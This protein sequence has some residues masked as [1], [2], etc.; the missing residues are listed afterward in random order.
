MPARDIEELFKDNIAKGYSSRKPYLR[1]YTVPSPYYHP[2]QSPTGF[3]SYLSTGLPSPTGVLPQTLESSASIKTEDTKT[4]ENQEN[5]LN[6]HKNAT[7]S[8]V[9]PK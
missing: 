9:I 6:D 8:K 7:I 3:H 1:L 2:S 4:T 5:L